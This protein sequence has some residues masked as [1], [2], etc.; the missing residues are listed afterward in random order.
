MC[1]GKL[2][3]TLTLLAMSG[4]GSDI[5]GESLVPSTVL[6]PEPL[7]SG[8][9]AQLQLPA[10][11]SSG[12][13]GDT[14]D[15]VPLDVIVDEGQGMINHKLMNFFMCFER[16][17]WCKSMCLL[18]MLS[19][20]ASSSTDLPIEKDGDDGNI[21]IDITQRPW[22]RPYNKEELDELFLELWAKESAKEVKVM[23]RGSL[24]KKFCEENGPL[25]RAQHIQTH[26]Q[27]KDDQEGRYQEEKE[28]GSGSGVP[29][30][31]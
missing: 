13:S 9:S 12:A 20:G 31:S 7:P 2:I 17:L 19:A 11:S 15:D 16:A 25:S 10:A 5:E 6:I 14:N 24:T 1:E 4:S 26:W 28:R 3:A 21:D 23:E 22:N 29:A 18:N 27:L 30:G 8:P